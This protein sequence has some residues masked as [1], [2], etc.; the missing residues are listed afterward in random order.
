MSAITLLPT[1]WVLSSPTSSRNTWFAT[2]ASGARAPALVASCAI[3]TVV[4]R[5]MES[6]KTG[7]FIALGVLAS[8][9]SSRGVHQAAHR[10]RGRDLSAGLLARSPASLDGTGGSAY[11]SAH[12]LDR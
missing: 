2:C 4:C 9:S 5:T 6:I 3:S 10:R 7:T 8:G 1:P 11:P 12:E